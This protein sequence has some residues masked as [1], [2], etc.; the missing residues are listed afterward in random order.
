MKRD[1]VPSALQALAEAARRPHDPATL[2]LVR[3]SLAHRSNHVVARAARAAR[4]AELSALAANLI[5][6]FPRFLEDPIRRDP[7]CVAKT[8][9][10]HALLSLECPSPDVHL[11]GARHVQREPAFGE[12]ID[13]AV[14]LRG[15]SAMALVT[16]QHP[17]ALPVCVDLL[18]D[19]EP[20]AR[21][22]AL[23]ALGASG[24]P[25]VALVLRHFVLRGEREPGVLAE[26][27]GGL[28]VLAPDE[29]SVLL[30]AERLAVADDD[31]ARAAAAALGE[32]RRPDA[33]RAL[34]GRLPREDRSD[35]RHALILALATSRQ[36]E[37]FDVLVDLVARGSEA[38]SRAALDAV[39]LYPHDE[40]LQQRIQAAMQERRPPRPA[41]RERKR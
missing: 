7:G 17:A 6:A 2:A 40:T 22:G 35:V 18:V 32:A 21:A 27:F 29:E 10:A 11:A 1:P 38:D 24:R 36:D 8:E 28:I 39:R 14:E 31:V 9:I 25:D 20:E 3:E 4:E 41:R 37:A 12:P 33:A 13:T 23:R 5:A 19:R 15:I 16:T 34:R 26:A 30:V